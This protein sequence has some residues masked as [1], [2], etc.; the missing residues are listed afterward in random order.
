MT[1]PACDS[2]L[3]CVACRSEVVTMPD[4]NPNSVSLATSSACS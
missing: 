4:D 1:M 2:R 3:K